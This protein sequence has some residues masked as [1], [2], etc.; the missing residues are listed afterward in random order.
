MRR[1]VVLTSVLCCFACKPKSGE[2]QAPACD[3][4]AL[5]ATTT[6]L[7]QLPPSERGSAAWGGLKSACGDALPKPFVTHYEAEGLRSNEQ[8][9]N[10]AKHNTELEPLIR[11]ACSDWDTLR[12]VLDD[13]GPDQ[14]G[15][16]SFLAC[17]AK[18]FEIA[19]APVTGFASN[20]V[21]WALHQWLLDSGID[22]ELAVPITSVM[23]G[24]EQELAAPV[25]VPSGLD[26]PTAPGW[27]LVE[28]VA[29]YVSP[30]EIRVGG[31]SIAKLDGV[32]PTSVE[33]LRSSGLT[34]ALERELGK[35]VP[36]NVDEPPPAVLVAADAEV[37]FALMLELLALLDGAIAD[38]RHPVRLAVTSP[39]GGITLLDLKTPAQTKEYFPA[40]TVELTGEG[41][42]T[43]Q[44]AAE[45]A[46]ITIGLDDREALPRFAQ[47]VEKI[48]PKADTVII[49]ASPELPLQQIVDV[50]AAVR[51]SCEHPETCVLRHAL[52]SRTPAHQHH[53]AGRDEWGNLIGADEH[54]AYGVGGLNLIENGTASASTSSKVVQG[55]AKITGK[56]DGDIIRRIVRAHLNEVRKCHETGLSKNPVLA[57][58]VTINFVIGSTGKVAAAMVEETTLDDATV[59]NCIAKAVKRWTFPKPEDGGN[60]IVSYPFELSLE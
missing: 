50:I 5:R 15:Q 14:R 24:Y 2:E 27:P 9:R 30:Q 32:G 39:G 31:E 7:A 38:G 42:R 51:G 48:F 44:S 18:R 36:A 43:V 29:V 26:L 53:A 22:H 59:A 34:A 60:V 12:A 16:A 40:M 11:K 20:E 56:L 17:D 4:E 1:S 33:A 47:G 13:T 21:T 46:P 10:P 49:S 41:Q 8:L 54:V 57:G 45:E 23:L 58:S 35:F 28:G 25:R 55:E 37:S 52:L 3:T 6:A 19:G